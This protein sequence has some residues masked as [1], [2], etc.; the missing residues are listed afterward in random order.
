MVSPQDSA[1]HVSAAD[2]RSIVPVDYEGIAC[3]S[4]G[5]VSPGAAPG[6][7]GKGAALIRGPM[8]SRLIQ[9]L[10]TGTAWGELD[11]LILDMPPGTGD[12]QLTLGQTLRISASVLVTTPQKLAFVDVVKGIEMFEHLKARPRSPSTRP[13]PRWAPRLVGMR[14]PSPPPGTCRS[15]SSAAL[16]GLRHPMSCRA[17]H[18]RPSVS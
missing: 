18:P 14:A 5:M 1:V 17:T 10:A 13:P 8:V 7:G 3:M 6:A 9:Q 2:G 12:I 16:G 11:V 4:F 15:A